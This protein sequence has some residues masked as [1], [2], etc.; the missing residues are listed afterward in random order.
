MMKKLGL[1]F[2]AAAI[3]LAGC[4]TTSA[5]KTS[6]GNVVVEIRPSG[7]P[8]SKDRP[9]QDNRRIQTVSG[10]QG[11]EIIPKDVFIAI[12]DDK[13]RETIAPGTPASWI[14]NLPQGLKA[15]VRE[16]KAGSHIMILLVEGIPAVTNTDPLRIT[17]PGGILS[18]GYDFTIPPSENIRF[19]IV[20]AAI[21]LENHIAPVVAGR[22]PNAQ[23]ISG[24]VGSAITARDVLITLRAA[25]LKEEIIEEAK[26]GWITNLPKGLTAVVHPAQAGAVTLTLTV[27][28]TPTEPKDQAVLVTIP[29]IFLNRPA[30]L[31][32]TPNED[33]RFDIVGITVKDVTIG[34]YS[35]Y[36]IN[37]KDVSI[38]VLG[39]VLRAD[40][41]AGTAVSWITN[42]PQGLSARV[43]SAPGRSG[44]IVLTVTGTPR[45][46]LNAPLAVSI[47]PGILEGNSQ[48]AARGNQNARFSIGTAEQYRS[49]DAASGS[50]NPNWL[51]GR[52][53]PLDSPNIP[54]IKDFEGVG[55][56]SVT[57][58]AVETL[59]P[60]SRYHWSG[61]YVNYGKLMVEARRL[62]AHAIINVV[63]DYEDKVE[64]T[65]TVKTVGAAYEYTSEEISRIAAGIIQVRTVEGVKQLEESIHTITRTYTG[66]ALAIRYTGG[67]NYFEVEKLKAE[68]TPTK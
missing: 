37:P 38:T 51:G 28:G 20:D 25:A 29:S 41:A 8:I 26:V 3:A 6:T 58:Q 54:A 55:I 35:G 9:V 24:S 60:D 27:T 68:N 1:L 33:I 2:I 40:I 15:T 34:G 16:A 50:S 23:Y 14:S 49:L 17:L 59:G 7:G 65:R 13:I 43:K 36:A 21:R 45:E 64:Y 18:G 19:D 66:T 67:I 57:T 62:G 42:L 10:A 61:D 52:S 39:S 48:F 4:A 31:A 47:P 32:I 11:S 22:S 53:S 46:E 30:D 5:P 12:Q 44:T 56:I 63:I